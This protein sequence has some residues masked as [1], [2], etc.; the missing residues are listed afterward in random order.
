M[1][2]CAYLEFGT[3]V[4]HVVQCTPEAIVQCESVLA[5]LLIGKVKIQPQCQSLHVIDSI[6]F[7]SETKLITKC[8]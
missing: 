7:E 4:H 6:G 1:E 3:V 8:H 5:F 2:E